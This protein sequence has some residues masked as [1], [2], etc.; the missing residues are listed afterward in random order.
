MK[1][2][3]DG[4]NLIFECGL[5]GR[6]TTAESLARARREL[7]QTIAAHIPASG[8]SDVTIVYDAKKQPLS[9][10][11][12]REL[13]GK[14]EVLY[15][16]HFEEADD[17]IEGL[18]RKHAVPKDLVVVSSDHRIHKAALR[19]KATPI[20]SGDWY[21]WLVAGAEAEPG[22]TDA[23]V[24]RDEGIRRT[25]SNGSQQLFSAE[26]LARFQSELEQEGSQDER[27]RLL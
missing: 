14:I 26:E 20:D 13:F 15:S 27:D 11:Q 16:I 9:G 4:Y 3:I 24:V 10:Q 25:G 5:Q 19:R 12:D 8:H 23:A 18:I 6:Q 2:L 7:Q 1:Y 21:D 22:E 17:L